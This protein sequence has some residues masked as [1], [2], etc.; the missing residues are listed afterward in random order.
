MLTGP[1]KLVSRQ[2]G[3]RRDTLFVCDD[4][5]IGD[6]INLTSLLQELHQKLGLT[7]ART[8]AFSRFSLVKRP[9]RHREK[10]GRICGLV[11]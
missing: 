9:K 3:M 5:E 6:K 11:T 7:D 8:P 1:A 4:V 2:G 10:H